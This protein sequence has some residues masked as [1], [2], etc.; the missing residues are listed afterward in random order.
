MISP[1]ILIFEERILKMTGRQI[2]FFS[3]GIIVWGNLKAIP[4]GPLPDAIFDKNIHTVVFQKENINFSYPILELNDQTPLELSFDELNEQDKNLNYS[5]VFC[6]ADWMPSRL[7][8]TEYMDGFFQNS[9]FQY[10]SSFNTNVPYR[11]YEIKVPNENVTL[12]LPGNYVLMVY[13]GGNDNEPVLMKRFVVV[14]SRVMIKA[15]VHR[16]VIPAYQNGFQEVDFSVLHPDYP[17]DNPYQTVKVAIV[18][19]NQW[20]NSITGLNPLFIRDYELTYNYEDK[21]LFPGGNEYRSFDTKS[22]KYQ[23]ANVKSIDFIHNQYE[24]VL[25]PDKK[26]NRL[27]YLYQND[28]NGQFLVQNQQGQDST[29]DAEYVWI[30]FTLLSFE[31]V[32]DGNVYVVGGFTDNNCYD[33]NKMVYDS[34]KGDYELRML[35]KQ[36][37]Y[38]YQYVFQDN[39]GNMDEQL[40]EGNYYETENN[41]VIYFYYRPYGQRYDSL[42]GVLVVNSITNI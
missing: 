13:E 36:G 10:R 26:R 8:Y 25:N 31:E 29:V 38:N 23:Q 18:K 15:K 35:V 17:I 22:L 16:P 14:D 33:D 27:P 34:E 1:I 24:V 12:K 37:Y 6:D 9:L 11:H 19:N 7:S 21:N 3:I 42:L 39:K 5:V 40:L 4:D 32:P 20:N 2:I 30:K 41:Y 28:L